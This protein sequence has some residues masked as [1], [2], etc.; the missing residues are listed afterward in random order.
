MTNAVITS[1][2]GTRAR[3][4]WAAVR[5]GW[6]I[7]SNW[8]D[9]F[10]FMTYQIIR[11]LFG[12]LILVVMYRVIRGTQADPMTFAQIYVGNAFFILVMQSILII[13]LIVF[14]DRERYEMF[15]YIYL[16]PLGL[17]TY[18]LARGASHVAATGASIVLTLALGVLGFG[19]QMN[20]GWAELPYF[21]ATLSLGVIATLAM[22]LMLASATML[23]AFH[24]QS[25]PEGVVG[26]L[27]LVSGVV[28][29]VDILPGI[30]ADIGRWL[31]W[32]YW[33]EGTRHVL[34][35]ASFNTSLAGLSDNAI[36]FRLLFLTTA[37]SGA[38]ALTLH[39]A[40]RIAVAK[41]KIDEKTDH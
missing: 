34:L 38:A 36:L 18:I 24:G 25:M 8:T 2:L 29:P 19:I 26:V 13:G 10:V 16:T 28:F 21:M 30:F 4:I 22:G 31:P 20:L 23:L 33:L 5:L 35:G 11:P 9:P 12:T 3:Q 39:G 27:F 40:R 14:E 6:A 37:L 32:T 41:G 15:R 7:E 17:G 1:S